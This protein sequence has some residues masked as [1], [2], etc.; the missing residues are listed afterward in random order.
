VLVVLM[1]KSAALSGELH[2]QG[3]GAVA[4]DVDVGNSRR[5]SQLSLKRASVRSANDNGAE[6]SSIPKQNNIP[7]C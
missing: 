6:T 4:G 1:G 5:K 7:G 3:S 2:N